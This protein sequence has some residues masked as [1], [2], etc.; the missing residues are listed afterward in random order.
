M[1]IAGKISTKNALIKMFKK[2]ILSFYK[3]GELISP[4]TFFLFLSISY[5]Q[6]ELNNLIHLNLPN[7]D[8]NP[9][10][11]YIK[12]LNT[13][14]IFLIDKNDSTK[15]YNI[16]SMLEINH[17]IKNIS[18]NSKLIK[19]FNSFS[20]KYDLSFFEI[21]KYDTALKS[22]ISFKKKLFSP[23]IFIQLHDNKNLSYGLGCNFDNK[24]FK[25]SVHY[26]LYQYSYNLIFQYEDFIY[27]N[28]FLRNEEIYKTKFSF[29][30]SRMSFLLKMQYHNYLIDKSLMYDSNQKIDDDKYQKYVLQ[31]ILEINLT[32]NK[33][34]TFLGDYNYNQ[35]TIDLINNNVKIIKINN[36]EIKNKKLQL[37]YS[38]TKSKNNFNIGTIYKKT[39]FT[40]TGR[41]RPSLISQNLETL[42]GA[43]IINNFDNGFI[44]TN[45]LFF[46]YHKK[47]QEKFSYTISMMAL[48]DF[49][50]ITIKTDLINIFVDPEVQID[51]FDY[52][53]KS[54][55]ELGLQL[56]YNM[57]KI[58]FI[59]LFNQHIPIKIKKIGSNNESTIN[60]ESTST[61]N[62][63]R[64]GGGNLQ[65]LVVRS[66]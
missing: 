2:H 52:E 51:N 49:Y 4:F 15:I 36:L 14:D 64:Y 5:T 6:L 18:I 29:N 38:F 26:K 37:Q 39:F 27:S 23:H 13:S 59:A 17:N 54:A 3:R 48:K 41:L 10:N 53:S 16:E 34:I 7:I 33:K 55:I 46:S 8:Q 57:K 42:L 62:N 40:L 58:N 43:P 21:R 25:T 60:N 11:S 9:N 66:F 50:D 31:N 30:K 45:G 47:N 20:T 56:N 24:N 19:L 28:T 65:L 35:Q 61:I 22:N 63:I 32:R 1:L 12:F 44:K